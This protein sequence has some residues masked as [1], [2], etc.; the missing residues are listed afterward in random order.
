MGHDPVASRLFEQIKYIFFG[1]ADPNRLRM[2]AYFM[3]ACT[4]IFNYF[5]IL[6]RDRSSA[7]LGM[8]GLTVVVGLYGYVGWRKAKRLSAQA[9]TCLTCGPAA[10]HA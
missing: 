8:L 3:W 6:E 1:G 7:V 5:A 4:P 9:E 10:C 2:G